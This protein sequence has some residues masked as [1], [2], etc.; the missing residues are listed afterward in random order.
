[1]DSMTSILGC[2]LC[3]FV[4]PLN[5]TV[6]FN[7]QI[8]DAFDIEKLIRGDVKPALSIVGK[9]LN[10]GG[11]LIAHAIVLAAHQKRIELLPLIERYKEDERP[12]VRS[13]AQYALKRLA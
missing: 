9:N 13:A 1:M 5:Q 7:E 3:Q 4:C 10:S 12:A 8:P 2:E 6:P 11:R